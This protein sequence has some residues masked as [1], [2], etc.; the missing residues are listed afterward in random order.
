MGNY[1]V[2]M[3]MQKGSKSPLQ[4]GNILNEREAVANVWE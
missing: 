2:R 4:H 3:F 1:P